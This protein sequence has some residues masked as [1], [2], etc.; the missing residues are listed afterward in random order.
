[1]CVIRLITYI[2]LTSCFQKVR[3]EGKRF[4]ETC[5]LLQG[6]EKSIFSF[7]LKNQSFT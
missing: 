5:D 6:M 2:L 3:N 4:Q 7:P 1:M